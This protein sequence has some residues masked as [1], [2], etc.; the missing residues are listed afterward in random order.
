MTSSRSDSR[1]RDFADFA[2]FDGDLGIWRFP[3]EKRSLLPTRG[4]RGEPAALGSIRTR[5]AAFLLCSAT[6][7]ATTFCILTRATELGL[8]T[9]SPSAPGLSPPACS[10]FQADGPCGF[11]GPRIA[12]S[13]L[14]A[15]APFGSLPLHQA[16]LWCSPLLYLS[17]SGSSV[18]LQLP[19]LRQQL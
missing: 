13:A 6:A 4:D 2:L 17:P 11:G 3:S 14:V 12:S 7:P 5:D 10:R 16:A 9:R 8:R 1:S 19:D 18:A 15:Q